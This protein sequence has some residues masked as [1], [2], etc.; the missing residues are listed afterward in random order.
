MRGFLKMKRER[1]GYSYDQKLL[2]RSGRFLFNAVGIS[3][4]IMAIILEFAPYI[5]V[6]DN[7]KLEEI[8]AVEQTV[9][10]V[11]PKK[12]SSLVASGEGKPVMLVL[13]A[14]WCSYCGKL[15][16]RILEAM[17]EHQLDHV[18]PIFV[19]MDSQPRIFS[20]YL[21]R[22][23]YYKSFQPIMLQELFYNNL[24]EVMST[25][26]SRF[27]GAIPYVGFFNSKGKMV[28]E[29]IGLV[30]KQEFLR[31]AQSVKPD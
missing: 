10:K 22:T 20:K 3:L 28:A 21:V 30:D 31:V 6:G 12:V 4:V 14:S 25:T 8:K 16:P 9:Q 11:Y 1:K 26:G 29:I 2:P 23:Q 15:M 17:Q 24:P 5:E 19:S 27:S 7:P 18:K 13:Y